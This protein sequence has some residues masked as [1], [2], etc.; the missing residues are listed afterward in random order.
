MLSYGSRP[1]LPTTRYGITVPSGRRWFEKISSCSVIG[2]SVRIPWPRMARRGVFRWTRMVVISFKLA[3]GPQSAICH[4]PSAICHLHKY[5]GSISSFSP[6]R[7]RAAACHSSIMII[8]CQ[9]DFHSAV[10]ISPSGPT[11]PSRS[12]ISN[13]HHCKLA[14]ELS[15]VRNVQAVARCC[16]SHRLAW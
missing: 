4:L 14:L 11:S 8:R 5:S 3:S 15:S 2:R 16:Q 1:G 10:Y 7:A 13:K 12:F 9:D 6:C